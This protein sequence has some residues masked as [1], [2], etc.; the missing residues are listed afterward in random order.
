MADA[1]S[2]SLGHA[3]LAT[4]PQPNF[5]GRMCGSWGGAREDQ[6]RGCGTMA[7]STRFIVSYLTQHPGIVAVTRGTEVVLAREHDYITR[8]YD[9]CA[10]DGSAIIGEYPTNMK[11]SDVVVCIQSFS[12]LGGHDPARPRYHVR[13]SVL[14]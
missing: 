2:Y 8:S 10:I 11:L 9:S 1:N 5:W 7:H 3:P 6:V 13:D 12:L 14:T 4:S